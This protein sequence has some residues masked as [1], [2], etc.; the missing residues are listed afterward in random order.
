MLCSHILHKLSKS[1]ETTNYFKTLQFS[2]LVKNL[3]PDND[4]G[5]DEDICLKRCN[6]TGQ[7]YRDQRKLLAEQKNVVEKYTCHFTL[8]NAS[9]RGLKRSSSTQRQDLLRLSGV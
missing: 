3:G 9:S 1:S 8:K 5:Y 4:F 6:I 2:L 7:S